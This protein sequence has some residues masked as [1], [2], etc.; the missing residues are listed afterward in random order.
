[1]LYRGIEHVA[2]ASA[3]TAR[4]ARWYTDVLG[5]AVA[6][7]DGK[8]PPAFLLKTASGGLL[9]IIPA[10][11]AVSAPLRRDDPGIRHLA[12]AVDDFDAAHDDLR[13]KGV[14]FISEPLTGYGNRVR[15][16][17]DCDGNILHL[18][19]RGQVL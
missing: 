18:I 7:Q 4:L 17:T 16:F 8:D 9:E 12:I 14:T 1:M 3:D 5:F 2:L 11:Q 6:W 15:F 13:C 10:S 19:Q